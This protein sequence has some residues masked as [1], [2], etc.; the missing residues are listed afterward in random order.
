FFTRNAVPYAYDPKAPA[1]EVWLKFLADLWGDDREQIL[2]LQEV[3]GLLLTPDTS[4][5][6]F[7]MLIGPTRGGKGVII[8]TMGKLLGST[9]I[10]SPY[11]ADFGQRFGLSKTLGKTLATVS[12]MRLGQRADKQGIVGNLLR[13]V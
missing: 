7:F 11:L 12:D 8:R 4:M 13:I 3:M 1:P 9:S 2:L 10:C 6:K 5:Q